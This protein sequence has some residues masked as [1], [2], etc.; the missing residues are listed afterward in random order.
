MRTR[1]SRFIDCRVNC[2]PS[3]VCFECAPSRRS[4]HC[5]NRILTTTQHL[6]LFS[7]VVYLLFACAHAHVRFRIPNRARGHAFCPN[8]VHFVRVAGHNYD[9]G[10]F[11][12]NLGIAWSLGAIS[13]TLLDLVRPIKQAANVYNLANRRISNVMNAPCGNMS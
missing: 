3:D 13:W 1:W 4:N 8:R 7:C 10:Q 9:C 11:S 5:P 6:Q 12:M 2:N